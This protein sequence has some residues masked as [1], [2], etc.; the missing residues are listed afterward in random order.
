MNR[1]TLK[2]SLIILFFIC[3]PPCLATL[4]ILKEK[5]YGFVE[6]PEYRLEKC[7]SQKI[8]LDFHERH[9]FALALNRKCQP[10]SRLEI[11]GHG[12]VVREKREL[13]TIVIAASTLVALTVNFVLDWK[14]SEQIHAEMEKLKQMQ[15]L[16]LSNSNITLD[17]LKQ[18]EHVYQDAY[19]EAIQTAIFQYG[20]LETVM[21]FFKLDIDKMVAEFEF[22]KDNNNAILE[23]FTHNFYCG[24]SANTY[25]LEVCGWT[26]PTRVYGDVKLIAPIGNFIHNG[27][28]FSYYDTPKLTMFTKNNDAISTDGCESIGYHWSCKKATKGC[29]IAEY[30]NCTPKIVHTPDHVFAV[31]IE[32]MTLIA[33]TLSHYSLFKDGSN[34]ASSVHDVPQSGQFLLKAPHNT[35]AQFGRR[36]FTGRHEEHEAIQ[37][38]VE[39]K[40]PHMDHEKIRQFAENLKAQGTALSEFEELLLHDSVMD[41]GFI[42]SVLHWLRTKFYWILIIGGAVLLVS[43]VGTCVLAYFSC[44]CFVRKGSKSR[45]GDNNV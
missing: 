14:R 42:D 12:M 37:I 20:K 45:N 22:E 8:R 15:H 2:F 39:E 19:F 13:T 32:D 43:I 29:T 26:N 38:N 40:M 35:I 23:K 1:K 18:Q 28:A 5:G 16:I 3:F 25:E 17:L 24:K 6:D 44:C 36:R 27:E 41:V 30:K 10:I 4:N 31:E 21:S 33:T 7:V 11:D 9:A 34:S